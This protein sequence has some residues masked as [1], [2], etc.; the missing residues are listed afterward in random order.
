MK[1]S[2]KILGRGHDAA[3]PP[4]AMTVSSRMNGKEPPLSV[5]SGLKIAKHHTVL[6]CVMTSI[7]R[8]ICPRDFAILRTANQHHRANVGVF[9]QID[10]WGTV[11]LGDPVFI[12]A[13]IGWV[14]QLR[15]RTACGCSKGLALLFE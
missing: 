9:A 13:C 8:M 10:T 7:T 4:I 6:P 11:H 5:G 1:G 14:S 2:A 12:E 3:F 15:R